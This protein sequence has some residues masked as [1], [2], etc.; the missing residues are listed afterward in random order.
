MTARESR[1]GFYHL[2][3]IPKANFAGHELWKQQVASLDECPGF[4]SVSD[5]AIHNWINQPA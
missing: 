5:Y 1:Y 2:F 3:G 4:E